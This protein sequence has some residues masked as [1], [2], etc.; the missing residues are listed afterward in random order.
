MVD[1]GIAD[2]LIVAK[3]VAI[4]AA[5]AAATVVAAGVAVWIGAAVGTT[6]A[7]G[8][9]IIVGHAAVSAAMVPRGTIEVALT[10]IAAGGCSAGRQRARHAPIAASCNA[11]VGH[12]Q[13]R[14]V[15]GALRARLIAGLVVGNAASGTQGRAA[16][17]SRDA[18]LVL[19][20]HRAAIGD[21]AGLAGSAAA[22]R[23]GVVDAIV[24]AAVIPGVAFDTTGSPNAH[25]VAVFG[26]RAALATGSAGCRILI[27]HAGF[28]TGVRPGSAEEAARFA[29]ASS[30]HCPFRYRARLAGGSAGVQ[31]GV[32]GALPRTLVRAFRASLVAHL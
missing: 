1:V 18:A 3:V 31:T 5:Q 22:F 17:A 20:S 19:A 21:D 28:A 11:V 9:S 14:A 30:R 12:A 15:V 2:A 27:A 16:R 23:T 8:R 6:A 26:L 32:R 4:V 13:I 25:A 24:S 29:I 10:V 7:T